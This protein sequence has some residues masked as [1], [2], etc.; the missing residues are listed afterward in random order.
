MDTELSTSDNE[1]MRLIDV[2]ICIISD[3]YIKLFRFLPVKHL[4]SAILPEPD[5]TNRHYPYSFLIKSAAVH[6]KIAEE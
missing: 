2:K 4:I 6:A 5:L 3:K 1:K